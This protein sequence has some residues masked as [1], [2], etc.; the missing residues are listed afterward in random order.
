MPDTTQ[1]IQLAI[2]ATPEAIWDALTN[3]ETTPAYY[4]GY[5]AH[6]ELAAGRPY[7]YTAD[8]A[9]VITG[10]VVAVDPGR[11]L[12]MTF[13]GHWDEAVDAL[14][15]S[16]VTFTLAEPAMPM[17]GVTILACVH[18]ELPDSELARDIGQGW[19]VILSGLKTLLETGAPMTSPDRIEA[20]ATV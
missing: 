3:G 12:A 17:P 10:Q 4:L 2:R 5:V 19:V 13:H 6:L 15:E 18:A 11:E 14:P 7:R 8:G 20:A 9:D 1:R 16:R